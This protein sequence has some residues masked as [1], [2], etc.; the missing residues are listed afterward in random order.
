MYESEQIALM[1]RVSRIFQEK[2]KC[3]KEFS[4]W[5]VTEMTVEELKFTEEKSN[6]I[7]TES[8]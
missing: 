4:D 6:A 5:K 7:H 2:H 3:T 1:N 8:R